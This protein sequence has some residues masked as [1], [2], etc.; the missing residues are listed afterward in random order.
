VAP[1]TSLCGPRE[2]GCERGHNEF[3]MARACRSRSP[4]SIYTAVKNALLCRPAVTEHAQNQSAFGDSLRV[5]ACN[6][7]GGMWRTS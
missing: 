2:R 1:Q 7:P 5:R 3:K 6:T 4:D